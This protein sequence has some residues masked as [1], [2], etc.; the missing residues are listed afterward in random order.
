[1]HHTKAPENLLKAALVS[2]VCTRLGGALLFCT[3]DR[4]RHLTKFYGA[5]VIKP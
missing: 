3:V 1:M 4:V 2:P 5:E